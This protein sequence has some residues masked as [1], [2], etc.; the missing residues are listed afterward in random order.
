MKSKLLFVF[1]IG[2]NIFMLLLMSSNYK[3]LDPNDVYHVETLEVGSR[4]K[5][6]NISY[7]E[8]VLKFDLKLDKIEDYQF[9]NDE[10]KID[11]KI[12]MF[13]IDNVLYENSY[14]V[15]TNSEGLNDIK[16]NIDLESYQNQRILFAISDENLDYDYNLYSIS[17]NQI[18]HN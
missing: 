18:L 1:L 15:N 6:K 9:D 5:I 13:E 12:C 4:L 7:E 8:K 11:L 17:V 3:R 14:V 10:V 16:V 2:C